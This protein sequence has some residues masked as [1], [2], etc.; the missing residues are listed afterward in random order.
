MVLD[1][2]HF[3]AQGSEVIGKLVADELAKAVPDLAPYIRD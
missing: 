3:N 1:N 2:T